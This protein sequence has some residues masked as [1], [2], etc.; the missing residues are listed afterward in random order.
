MNFDHQGTTYTLA[1][2]MPAMKAYQR[3]TGET[4]LDGFQAV[5]T[6]PGDMVRWSALFRAACRPAVS[7]EEA[8]AIMDA[9]TPVAAMKMLGE[10][11]TAAFVGAESPNPIAP[12]SK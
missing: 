4:V 7:E 8:D 11:A 5:E 10:A 3:E 6:S 12:P 2:K 1:F 9:L